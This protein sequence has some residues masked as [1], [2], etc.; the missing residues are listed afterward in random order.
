MLTV[1]FYP[2]DGSVDGSGGHS[3]RQQY[4]Q[5]RADHA[6]IVSAR[7]HSLQDDE[8]VTRSDDYVD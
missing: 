7:K 5:M 3:R 2:I 6:Q 4:H 8:H 1:I